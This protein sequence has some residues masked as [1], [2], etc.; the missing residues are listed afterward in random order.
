MTGQPVP[1]WARVVA[2]VVGIMTALLLVPLVVAGV[3]SLASTAARIDHTTSFDV[4]PAVHLQLDARFGSV[5]VEAARASRIVVHDR[6]SASA[7]T[8][9][10]AA[11]ALSKF[12][13]DVSHQGDQVVIRQDR[14]LFSAPEV[15]SDSTITIEVPTR[16][17]LDADNVGDL[18]IQGIDGTVHVRGAGSVELSGVTLRGT[19][20]FDQALGDVQMSAVTV[21]GSAAV[22]KTV[23]D[24]RFDGRLAPGGA[25]L[26]IQNRGGNVSVTL[27]RQTDARA[28]VTAQVGDFHPDRTWLF[29]PDTPVTPRRWTADLGPSPT[30]TVT[31]RTDLGS[32]S[33]AGR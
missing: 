13:V 7:I 31:V 17:D 14:A 30:G 10:A 18:R 23:G 29:T 6:R 19:S 28:V 9:T 8:R 12:A 15:N 5:A 27:P 26:D 22:K 24:V 11:T 20:L 4:G 21:A 16:T 3:V 2:V 1:T 25:A 33:F 32:V